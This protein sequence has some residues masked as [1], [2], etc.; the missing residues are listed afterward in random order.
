ME[1][2]PGTEHLY[3]FKSNFSTVNDVKE[4]TKKVSGGVQSTVSSFIDSYVSFI[5]NGNKNMSLNIPPECSQSCSLKKNELGLLENNN[6]ASEVVNESSHLKRRKK[7]KYHDS[8]KSKNVLHQDSSLKNDKSKGVTEIRNSELSLLINRKSISSDDNSVEN[9]C[10]GSETSKESNYKNKRGKKK[11]CKSSS[12]ENGI[13]CD[14]M[15]EKDK[16]GEVTEII[17][18]ER[19]LPLNGKSIS[20]ENKF[21]VSNGVSETAIESNNLI[22]R[23]KKK[24]LHNSVLEDMIRCDSLLDK[25]RSLKIVGTCS[26]ALS[27]LV[28][29]KPIS[30]EN[31][32]LKENNGVSEIVNGSSYFKKRSKNRH[33]SSIVENVIHYDSSL[34]NNR[35]SEVIEIRS[36]ELSSPANRVSISSKNKSLGELCEASETTNE[37]NY[38]N[39]REKKKLYRSPN[40]ENMLHRDSLLEEDR[41]LEIFELCSSELSSPVK[42]KSISSKKKTLENNCGVL[43]TTNE[44]NYLK[45]KK[46]KKPHNCSRLENGIHYD[47]LLEND[48]GRDVSEIRILKLSSPMNK[49]PIS[50]EKKLLEKNCERFETINKSNYLKKSKK[51]EKLHDFTKLE[52]MRRELFLEKKRNMEVID[53]CSSELS[54]S[55]ENN[56]FENSISPSKKKRK[57]RKNNSMENKCKGRVTLTSIKGEQSGTNHLTTQIIEDIDTDCLVEKRSSTSPPERKK[58]KTGEINCESSDLKRKQKKMQTNQNTT[59]ICV[60]E[61]SPSFP[62]LSSE[63]VGNSKR[64][65]KYQ[66]A[67]QN[68]ASINLDEAN[69][70]LC[71]WEPSFIVPS[72]LS[73]CDEI[74]K[75]DNTNSNVHNM[76]SM[77][78]SIMDDEPVYDVFQNEK[79]SSMDLLTVYA[80]KIGNKKEECDKIWNDAITAEFGRNALKKHEVDVNIRHDIPLLHLVDYSACTIPTKQER[81]DLVSMGMKQIP[82][83]KSEDAIIMNNWE[84][85]CIDN[86]VSSSELLENIKRVGYKTKKIMVQYLG[87]GLPDRALYQIYNR[88]ILLSSSKRGQ[89]TEE[90][91]YIL[92]KAMSSDVKEKYALLSS[93]LRRSRNTIYKRYQRLLALPKDTT[94]CYEKTNTKRDI[95]FA[96]KIVKLLMHISGASSIEDFRDIVISADLWRQMEK[97]LNTPHWKLHQ[98]WIYKLHVQLFAKTPVSENQVQKKI[99]KWLYKKNYSTEKEIDWSQS[100]HLLCGSTPSF[101]WLQFRH[102]KYKFRFQNFQRLRDFIKAVYSLRDAFNEAPRYLTRYTV[103]ED[104]SLTAIND[105]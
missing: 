84:N 69:A 85:L 41:S 56:V 19:S 105:E 62:P 72:A 4:G 37:S 96:T 44:L 34:E 42:R 59:D 12:S 13:F 38:S 81:E 92:L 76:D 95:I 88:F 53:V 64:E 77:M 1:G 89:F 27:S 104:F 29:R 48:R 103:N 98:F 17:S 63:S 31:Y 93:I 80:N 9:N 70:G 43:E 90:E 28:N 35:S 10:G 65:K 32:E 58:R 18:S 21:L 55:S 68:E 50:S 33:D 16:S 101:M 45:E 30:S 20:S 23:E 61:P 78:D 24:H 8:P 6:Y 14:S 91:D 51:K 49:K 5:E 86:C 54:I 60:F 79:R 94:G 67:L 75:P 87:N 82:F 66:F 22:K 40:S 83:N 36:C 74:E 57:L 52:N 102:V 11:H 97:A 99:V 3:S 7:K 100:R 39:K 26:S 73:S 25:D 46:K 71:T 47:S 15:F 2:K